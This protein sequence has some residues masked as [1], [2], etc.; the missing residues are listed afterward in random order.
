MHAK[1]N[2]PDYLGNLQALRHYYEATHINWE[3]LQPA[4]VVQGTN[5][6]CALCS[7]Y[8]PACVSQCDRCGLKDENVTESMKR[9]RDVRATVH[10]ASDSR[11]RSRRGRKQYSPCNRDVTDAG[12]LSKTASDCSG[13]Q[14]S[15]SKSRNVSRESVTVRDRRRPRLERS[16]A[17][18]S[19]CSSVNQNQTPHTTWAGNRNQTLRQYLRA[20]RNK[21][22]AAR[23]AR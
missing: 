1:G 10:G 4:K 17:S 21:R 12:S 13:S 7:T 5:S 23:S 6:F 19:A 3:Y 14:S 18:G 11:V 9:E 2:T 16:R 15:V 22:N 8:L 20:Q